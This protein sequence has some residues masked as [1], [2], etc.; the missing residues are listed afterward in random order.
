MQKAWTDNAWE[1]YWYWQTLDKRTLKRIKIILKDIDR[2]PFIGQGK[3]EPLKSDKQG[4]RSRRIDE[5]NRIVYKVENDQICAL[6]A[7]PIKKR[8][9]YTSP[10]TR[11]HIA[12][13]LENLIAAAL[14]AFFGY[15]TQIPV[16]S[17]I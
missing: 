15:I 7:C 4:Y 5:I 12:F 2:Q 8:K 14:T 17:A 13:V 3:P 10:R 11:T 9:R 1:D 16:A 6:Q